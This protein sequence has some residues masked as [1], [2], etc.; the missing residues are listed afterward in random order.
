MNG[1]RAY[2]MVVAVFLM[3]AVAGAA[4]MH[5]VRVRV[6]RSIA[7]SP[8]PV[9][10]ATVML[11]DRELSLTD[12]QETQIREEIVSARRQFMVDHP[13][14]LVDVK[15]VFERAQERIGT[16][17]TPEQRVIFDRLVAERRAIFD[18]TISESQ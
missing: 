13:T 15:A 8:E 9:A 14:L 1:W 4:G 2:A 7:S 17:L 18:R 10:Q 12:D 11:L 16:K 5:L 6:E 3:G